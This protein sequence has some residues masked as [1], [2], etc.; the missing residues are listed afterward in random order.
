MSHTLS[1]PGDL[2]HQFVD[3]A[4]WADPV[5][6]DTTNHQAMIAFARQLATSRR[7][8]VTTNYVIHEVVALLP[9][10]AQGVSRADLIDMVDHITA[11]QDLELIHVDPSTHAEA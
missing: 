1:L 7:W 9:A 10:K 8:L 2:Y 3:T 11:S 4:G 5:F 6:Q